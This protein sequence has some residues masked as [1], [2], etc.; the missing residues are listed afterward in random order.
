LF[1]PAFFLPKRIIIRF[2]A[3]TKG[4]LESPAL[5]VGS[6]IVSEIIRGNF[7]EAKEWNRNGIPLFLFFF[8]QLIMRLGITI[9]NQKTIVSKKIVLFADV[10]ISLLLFI[11]CFRSLIL[12]WT[13]Y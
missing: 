7:K 8:I 3:Y 5:P 9:L 2:H 13:Y 11:V 10:A 12:F 1:I 4:S 6:P